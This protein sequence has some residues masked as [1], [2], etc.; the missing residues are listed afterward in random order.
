[1]ALFTRTS[2]RVRPRRTPYAIASSR[3][4]SGSS[5][6]CS[7]CTSAQRAAIEPRRIVERI[8][9]QL[10]AAAGSNR[11][12]AGVPERKIDTMTKAA[13]ALL[14]DALR[15]SPEVR[16]EL[17]AELL[18]S[19]DGPADPEAETAWAAEIERRVDAIEGGSVA[20]EPWDEVKRR[21]EKDILGR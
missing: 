5:F 16:A 1:M 8:L 18:A 13:E 10:L 3:D 15:L 17:A 9:A 6:E 4:S 12:L 7:L 14:A 2:S 19:L 21:I 20:L 11:L